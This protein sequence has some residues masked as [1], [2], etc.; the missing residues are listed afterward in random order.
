MNAFDDRRQDVKGGTLAFL[1]IPSAGSLELIENCQEGVV[2]LFRALAPG[3][4]R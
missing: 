4:A 3:D 1:A 2:D